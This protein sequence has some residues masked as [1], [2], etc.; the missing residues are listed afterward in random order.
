MVNWESQSKT[1]PQSPEDG[2]IYCILLIRIAFCHVSENLPLR[3]LFYVNMNIY[4]CFLCENIKISMLKHGNF[5]VKT[6]DVVTVLL[7]FAEY[8]SL[9][10]HIF[11]C[12]YRGTQKQAHMYTQH[13]RG[14]ESLV[15]RGG[16]KALLETLQQP[17]KR[18]Q[19]KPDIHESKENIRAHRASSK[20]TRLLLTK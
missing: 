18:C 9:Y 2:H 5:Y 19:K 8:L 11:T 13:T 7:I 1:P 3:C 20:A 12:T 10:L 15:E 16:R 14:M 17:K 4:F 6:R